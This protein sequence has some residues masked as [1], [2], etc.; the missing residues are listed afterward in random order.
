MKLLAL[1]FLVLL[2]GGCYAQQTTNTFRVVKPVSNKAIYETIRMYVDVPEQYP[3]KRYTAVLYK[4]SEFFKAEADGEA[5]TQAVR[6][7][8]VKRDTGSVF[9][10]EAVAVKDGKDMVWRKVLRK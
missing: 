10:V 9:F 4:N 5:I 1:P 3:I 2:C 7:L 6:S 8:L